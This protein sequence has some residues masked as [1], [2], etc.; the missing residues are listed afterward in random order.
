MADVYQS[1][2]WVWEEVESGDFSFFEAQI[3]TVLDS[4][5]NQRC[6][7]CTNTIACN[8]IIVVRSLAAPIPGL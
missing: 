4:Y 1:V 5:Y 3:V 8:V 7:V 2:S 6:I